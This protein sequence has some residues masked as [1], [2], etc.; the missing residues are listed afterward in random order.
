MFILDPKEFQRWRAEKGLS[1]YALEFK[2]DQ[3]LQW[4][5]WQ[6]WLKGQKLRKQTHQKLRSLGV[7]ASALRPAPTRKS[8]R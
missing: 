3:P 1:Y 7:P 6:G 8:S 5:E 4:N 2:S